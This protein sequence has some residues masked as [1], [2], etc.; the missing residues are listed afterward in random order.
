MVFLL[1]NKFIG[2]TN[3]PAAMMVRTGPLRAES[4]SMRRSPWFLAE[5]IVAPRESLASMTSRRS[6]MR[7]SLGDLYP[8][9]LSLCGFESKVGLRDS[10]DVAASEVALFR[11]GVATFDVG[12]QV[13]VEFRG[14]I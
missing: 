6:A 11:V 1:G 13:E 14:E 8:M 9:F 2:S 10:N 12:Q 3:L 5:K 4:R 7:F